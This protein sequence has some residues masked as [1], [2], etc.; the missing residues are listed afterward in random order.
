[1]CLEFVWCCAELQYHV[2]LEI[3]KKQSHRGYRDLSASQMLIIYVTQY[4]KD[5]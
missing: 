3:L 2:I 5:K 1:M 4:L